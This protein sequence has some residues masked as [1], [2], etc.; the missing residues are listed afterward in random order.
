M[1]ALDTGICTPESDATLR[2]Q[3]RQ[4]T[5]GR[6]DVQMFPT[7]TS[8]LPLP[9]GFA[10]HRNARGVF[11][12]CPAKISV[13]AIEQ[14]SANDRENEFLNLGRF[15]K[16]DVAHRILGGER[17]TCITEYTPEGVE[18]RSAAGTDGTIDLQRAYF[19]ATQEPDSRLVIGTFPDRVRLARGGA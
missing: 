10:R 12:F 4:L 2:V 11:H 19:E 6:R 8:E 17:L 14:L 1:T 7:G 16:A 5:G 18:I 9:G 3:Q 13:A 15:S